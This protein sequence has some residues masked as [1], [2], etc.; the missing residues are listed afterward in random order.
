[1]LITNPSPL[2]SN[3]PGTL[4]YL[5]Y[6]YSPINNNK[7]S[8]INS[9]NIKVSNEYTQSNN[10]LYTFIYKYSISSPPN[11]NDKVLTSIATDTNGNCYY[12][13][14]IKTNQTNI[15]ASLFK[16]DQYTK[17]TTEINT[18]LPISSKACIT[19]N[20]TDNYLY[21]GFFTQNIINRYDT[22]GNF[23]SKLSYNNS[24]SE[25]INPNGLI[26]DVNNNLYISNYGNNSILKYF[27]NTLTTI[28]SGLN[29]PYG[30]A[31]DNNSNLYIAN[32]GTNSVLKFNLNV[33][34]P[35]LTTYF[36]R[37]EGIVQP[38]GI[39][40]DSNYN[41]YVSDFNY[42]SIYKI[43][44]TSGQSSSYIILINSNGADSRQTGLNLF[45]NNLYYLDN[46]DQRS[47]YFQFY[48]LPLDF[49][50]NNLILNGSQ[51][52]SIFNNTTLQTIVT[53]LYVNVISSNTIDLL[54]SHYDYLLELDDTTTYDSIINFIKYIFISNKN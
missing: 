5:N 50:F 54:I 37:G 11:N 25:L 13:N 20:S 26:F 44:Y 41:L 9:N 22:T 35:R 27:N 28:I 18:S 34:I 30:L 38:Y 39:V 7:Y 3:K 43:P 1:M 8:L 46:T 33:S 16:Y 15:G 14:N 47:N 12:V 19:Y 29:Q 52:L 4:T 49:N 45:N 10:L 17:Q 31:L 36:T 53:N 42:Q 32:W 40:F 48:E 2:L 51:P 21:I 23:I 24:L 6:D